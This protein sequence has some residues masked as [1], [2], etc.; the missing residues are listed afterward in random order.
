MK[1]SRYVPPLAAI[2]LVL[3]IAACASLGLRNP[4]ATAQT[5]EQKAFALVE[6][7]RV[8]AETAADIVENPATP[9]VVV[10][11]LAD[12]DNVATPLAKTLKA[13]AQTYGD[14]E[15]ALAKLPND[16]GLLEKLRIAAVALQSAW[17]RGAPPMQALI[18]AVNQVRAG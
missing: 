3:A 10:K 4:V 9:D 6:T 8:A 13:A 2:L 18:A 15:E 7:Y 17:A 11:Y 12:G 14:A 5:L 16:A 1:I